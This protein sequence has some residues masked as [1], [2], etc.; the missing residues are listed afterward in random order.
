[1]QPEVLQAP[2]RAVIGHRPQRRFRCRRPR[3]GDRTG[4][5]VKRISYRKGREKEI[6][7]DSGTMRRR[8]YNAQKCAKKALLAISANYFTVCFSLRFFYPFI[9]LKRVSFLERASFHS[10]CTFFTIFFCLFPFDASDIFMSNFFLPTALAQDSHLS[11]ND[12]A[13]V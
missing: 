11:S 6:D 3:R 10:V 13:I 12:A 5:I 8:L 9:S 1:M 7:A 4:G 2:K